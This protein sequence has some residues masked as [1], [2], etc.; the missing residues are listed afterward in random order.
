VPTP[1]QL[2]AFLQLGSAGLLALA[3]IALVREWVVPGT[4]YKRVTAERDAAY[5]R[6]DRMADIFAAETVKR[7]Q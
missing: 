5:T 1:E 4:A 7:G 2:Q 3:V 6:L